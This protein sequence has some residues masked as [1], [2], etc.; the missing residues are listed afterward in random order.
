MV[1]MTTVRTILAII[2]FES[3]QIHQMD[4]KNAFLH[5]DLKEKIYIRLPTGM[6]SPLSNVVC[7]LKRSLYGLKGIVILGFSFI[8]SRYDPSLFIQRSLKRIVILLVYVDDIVVTGSDQETIGT[9]KRLLHSTF[10]MKDL[11]QLTYFLGLEVHFQ[12]KGIFVNQHKYIQDLIQLVG[13]TNST[14]VDSPME[15]YLKL[16]R[17]E[18]VLQQDPTFYRKLVGSLIYLTITRLDISFAMSKF[19]QFPRH[20][21][22]SA[23]HHIIKYLFGTSSRGLFFPTGASTQLQAYSDSDWAG[24]PAQENPLLVGESS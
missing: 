9:I 19:M 13:L 4:V 18:G 23:V 11:G 24:C 20:L 17:D 5:G 2:A 14:L 16:R 3:W 12:Q 15:I 6:P 1:K 22:L 10:H 8:Q 7:K 21:H